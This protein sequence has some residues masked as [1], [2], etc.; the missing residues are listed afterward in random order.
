MPARI[1]PKILSEMRNWDSMAQEK[2]EMILS[3]V[4]VGVNAWAGIQEERYEIRSKNSHT[5][6]DSTSPLLLAR[7]SKPRPF[8]SKNI[9][10]L[11]SYPQ[12]FNLCS[13]YQYDRSRFANTVGYYPFPD[14]EVLVFHCLS[15]QQ[16]PHSCKVHDV[17]CHQ[18]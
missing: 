11:T 18:P 3:D 7:S 14:H 6:G 17:T 10:F 13:E 12:V 5:T 8:K 9:Q 1:H 4:S 16:V 2:Q 15:C